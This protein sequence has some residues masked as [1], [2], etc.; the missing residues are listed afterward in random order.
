[1]LKQ[2]A[3]RSTLL[4]AAFRNT[5]HNLHQPHDT[6]R[7]WPHRTQGAAKG[8]CPGAGGKVL[9][10][11][12]PTRWPCWCQG[13]CYKLLALLSMTSRSYLRK[14]C[15]DLQRWAKSTHFKRAKGFDKLDSRAA[16]SLGPSPSLGSPRAQT[17]EQGTSARVEVRHSPAPV[18]QG[19]KVKSSSGQGTWKLLL[20]TNPAPSLS[21]ALL[22]L[23]VELSGL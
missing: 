21:S 3:L 22:L 18:A 12:P 20:R 16:A 15:L 17:Q 23:G 9:Y 8:T 7:L 13:V 6:S 14:I 19:T 2:R 11:G 5:G 10:Q 1:M 4:A